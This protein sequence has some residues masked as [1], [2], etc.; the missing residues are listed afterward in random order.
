MEKGDLELQADEKESLAAVEAARA[1]AETRQKMKD[2]VDRKRRRECIPLAKEFRIFQDAGMPETADVAA[3][4]H[5]KRQECDVQEWSWNRQMDKLNFQREKF[6]IPEIQRCHADAMVRCR[7]I[8]KRR[9]Y[10]F[11]R[12]LE[13]EPHYYVNEVKTNGKKIADAIESV[14]RDLK[15]VQAMRLLPLHELRARIRKADADFE[16]VMAR[17]FPCDEIL[18]VGSNRLQ[19]LRYTEQIPTQFPAQRGQ[20]YSPFSTGR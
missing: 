11:V 2:D 1:H 10:E 13:N 9:T 5:L 17:G 16:I 15:E 18:R 19:D 3:R 14:L 7:I 4:L 6:T 8:L 12:R 20:F